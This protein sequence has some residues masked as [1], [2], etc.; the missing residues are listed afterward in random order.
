MNISKLVVMYLLFIPKCAKEVH[1]ALEMAIEG[2]APNL[3][4]FW[5]L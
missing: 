3:E 5:E 4:L 1:E 2:H